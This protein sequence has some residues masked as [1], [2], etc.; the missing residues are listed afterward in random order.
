MRKTII[1]SGWRDPDL[2]GIYNAI[3]GRAFIKLTKDALRQL[4]RAD[5]RPQYKIPEDI[6]IIYPDK[7]DRIQLE[8]YFNEEKDGDVI[9]LISHCKPRQ[10]GAFLKN[11]IRLHIGPMYVL[12]AFLEEDY[13]AQFTGRN[14]VQVLFMPAA[15]PPAKKE[16]KKPVQRKK[17]TP[18]MRTEI[19][20]PQSKAPSFPGQSESP[21]FTNS[22]PSFTLPPLQMDPE[23]QERDAEDEEAEVLSLLDGLLGD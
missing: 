18:V 21:S 14:M 15:T 22:A 23:I 19:S 9:E 13:N 4:V 12:S 20:S 7:T 8:F 3:G 6:Q 16:R 1:L 2:Y 5:Y 17:R 11:V 10:F